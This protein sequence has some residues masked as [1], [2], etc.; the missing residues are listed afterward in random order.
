MFNF[1]DFINKS[2]CRQRI[3]GWDI[4]YFWKTAI[5]YNT[6]SSSSEANMTHFG[7]TVI[8]VS[9]TFLAIYL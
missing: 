9:P 8:R 2:H 6:V 3:L 5:N 4:L 1:V 7:S